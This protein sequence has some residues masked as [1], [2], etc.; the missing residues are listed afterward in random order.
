MLAKTMTYSSAI[1]LLANYTA[2]AIAENGIW[3]DRDRY[4]EDYKVGVLNGVPYSND[5]ATQRRITAPKS[6]DGDVSDIYLQSA[7]VQR[8]KSIFD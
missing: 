6:Y 2:A 4:D 8:I 5:P 1:A 3:T 7:N